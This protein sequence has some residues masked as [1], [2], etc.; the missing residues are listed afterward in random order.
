M[1]EE[2]IKQIAQQVYDSNTK[3]DQLSTLKVP[4][5]VHNGIDSPLIPTDKIGTS[6]SGYS[7]IDEN[8]I[9]TPTSVQLFTGVQLFLQYQ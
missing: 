7:V 9:S 3:R 6:L 1:D 2:R 8:N 5:H 4:R